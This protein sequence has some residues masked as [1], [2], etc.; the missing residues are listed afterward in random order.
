[1]GAG[2]V[3]VVSDR[4]PMCHIT[5]GGDADMEPIV[6]SVLASSAFKARWRLI[7]ESP[8]GDMVTSEYQN[9][10]APRFSI[11]ISRANQPGARLDRVQVLATAVFNPPN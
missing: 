1:M 2:F 7:K 5:G 3:L 10:R 9:V 6:S 4:L 11:V 8:A